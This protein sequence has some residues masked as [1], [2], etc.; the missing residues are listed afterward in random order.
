MNISTPAIWFSLLALAACA[1]QPVQPQAEPSAQPDQPAAAAPPPVP[2]PRVVVRPNVPQPVLPAQAMSQAVLFKLLLAEIALQR[3]QNNVAVQS[4]V[5]LTKE[6]RDPRIAQRATEVALNTRFFGAALETAGIWLAADPESQQ[7]RQILAALL[8]NQA[9]LADAEPH[10]EKWLAADKDHVGNGFMQLNP[11]L[12]RHPDKAAVLQLTQNLAKPYAAVPEAHYSV[13]QAAWAAGQT[14]LA[15]AEIR[16][17]LK[18]RA[19]WEQAALFQ[20]QVLQ[21]TS[22]ADALAY[23]QSYLKTNPRAMDVRL[24]FARLLVT[25]KKY[26]EARNEFQVLLKEFPD[27]A[28]VTMAVALLSL[29]LNDFDQ[30]ETQ[31]KHALE[32]DYKDPDAVRFYLGQ[33]NEERKRPDDALR[34]YSSV[35]GGDQYVPSRARYAGILAKQGKLG[36]ARTYLQQAGRNGPERVQFTQAEAQLLRDANDYRAAFDLLGQAVAK[37]P[38]SA[39]LLYDQAMAAEKVDRMDV[40]ESNLRKVIQLKPDYAHAYN[41]LGYT[42]ADRNT[43]LDEA[44]TLVEQALKLA[45]DDPFIMDSM[46]WVLF[47]MSQTDAAITFLKRA[48]EIRPDAEIAAHLGEVLWAAGRQDEA[49]KVWASALKDNPANELLSSTVKKFS[50]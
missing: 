11:I 41:A 2:K 28:D 30:A 29:Q 19:D 46:G 20:G 9:R 14:P 12:A 23:Y 25:D 13:A 34:W 40:L 37:N 3:G 45:P 42:F 31:L 44:Y 50:P 22:N 21:R 6:T 7:A 32:T 4:F 49:K 24:S 47:R 33:V 5:E 35:T 39:E 18:L 48:F 36:D 8:V 17:A 38:N 16:T 27:N 1:Q 10:L 15:L 26:A 43:R